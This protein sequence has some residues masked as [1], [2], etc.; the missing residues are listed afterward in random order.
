MKIIKIEY[1]H[2]IHGILGMLSA[3][4]QLVGYKKNIMSELK[5]R[6]NKGLI[7]SV[8]FV[9]P[10][11]FCLEIVASMLKKGAVIRIFGMKI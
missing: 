1:Y 2:N 4:F 9:L 7:I 5:Y 8:L 10:I 11:A 3:I 6:R